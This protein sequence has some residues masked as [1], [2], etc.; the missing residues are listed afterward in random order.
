MNM[1]N[2]KELVVW[3]RA[4]NFAVAL[5]R[6]TENLPRAEQFGLT[7]QIRRSATSVPPNI[8]EGWGRGSTK[9]YIQFLTVARGSLMEL[10]THLIIASDLSYLKPDQLEKSQQQVESIGQMLNRLIQ[11]LQFRRGSSANPEPQTPN[12]DRSAN[13]ETLT[14][15]PDKQTHE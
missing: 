10:E 11:A 6:A 1:E 8:A 5:Y 3:Q 7:S 14:P 12:P 4:K 9:E 15:N 2:Y 13:P